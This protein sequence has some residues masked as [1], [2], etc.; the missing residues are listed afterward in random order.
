MLS[1][2]A[3]PYM[4]RAENGNFSRGPWQVYASVGDSLIGIS[5]LI[6]GGFFVTSNPIAGGIAL[7]YG[8]YSLASGAQEWLK[9]TILEKKYG[10]QQQPIVMVHK[11]SKVWT[12][13]VSQHLQSS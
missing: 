12:K 2:A 10:L 13:E 9:L 5:S 11:P 6:A 1:I 8:G 3:T 7:A 4:Q